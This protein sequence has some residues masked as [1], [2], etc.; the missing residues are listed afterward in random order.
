[1]VWQADHDFLFKLA[2]GSDGLG[3]VSV[4]IVG[5]NDNNGVPHNLVELS[6]QGGKDCFVGADFLCS[7]QQ[8]D[9][10]DSQHCWL[11]FSQLFEDVSD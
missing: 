11:L 6:E 5:G 7:K 1:M 9:I 3:K 2:R 8:V 10:L 4:S